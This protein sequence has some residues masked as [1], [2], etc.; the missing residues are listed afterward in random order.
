MATPG[1]L[2]RRNPPDMDHVAKFPLS[3]LPSAEVPTGVPV[4]IGVDWY[5]NFD[6]P[7]KGADGRWW[8]GRGDL[9]ALRGGHCVCLKSV[10]TDPLGWWDFYNQ[11][12]EG[13][14][15]GFGCSRMMSLLNRKRYY[16]RWLWD[17]AKIIDIWGDTNPGDSNGTSVRA[18]LHLLRTVGHVPW[19]SRYRN[20]PYQKR[21]EREPT[22]GEGIHV[23]RWATAVEDVLHVLAMPLAKKLGA[24]PILNSWGRAGY[25]HIVWMTGETFQRLIDQDGE[26][27]LVTDR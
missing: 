19:K 17:H 22:A 21:D 25:P 23:Y 20:E 9:G 7:Q 15:V 4:V 1:G 18:A 6:K 12:S 14:C 3:A 5:E 24:V 16:A 10:Q 8:I 27:G 11:G 2:G 26:V 13:A